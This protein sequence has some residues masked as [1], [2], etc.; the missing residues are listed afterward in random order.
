MSNTPNIPIKEAA[1]RLGVSANTLREWE[2]KENFPK[3][4]RTPGGQRRYTEKQL[5]EIMA[6]NPYA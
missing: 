4:L 2:K 1:K 6:Y 5:S 3:I